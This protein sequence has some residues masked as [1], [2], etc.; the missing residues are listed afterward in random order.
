MK[1]SHSKYLWLCSNIPVKFGVFL[2][3]RL[4][5]KSFYCFINL[6]TRTAITVIY[7]YLLL[8]NLYD[9]TFKVW[10]NEEKALHKII[11]IKWQNSGW[12]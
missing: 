1:I 6:K 5:C 7:R 9:C 4:L 3:S 11:C 10:R 8:E 12:D 2:K